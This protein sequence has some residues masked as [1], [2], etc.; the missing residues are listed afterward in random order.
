MSSVRGGRPDH[1]HQNHPTD[2]IHISGPPGVAGRTDTVL[3]RRAARY[4]SRSSSY[5]SAVR[6]ER[7]AFATFERAEAS[8]YRPMCSR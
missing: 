4:P 5:W 6:P 7:T 8:A 2:E 3:T 1:A